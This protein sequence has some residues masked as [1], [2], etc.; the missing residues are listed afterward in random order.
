M[1]MFR[2]WW[3]MDKALKNRGLLGKILRNSEFLDGQVWR[4]WNFLAK[5]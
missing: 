4:K 1:K 2:F 5:N 3:I